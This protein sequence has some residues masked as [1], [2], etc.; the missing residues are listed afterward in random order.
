MRKKIEAMGQLYFL[1]ALKGIMHA[2]KVV[3]LI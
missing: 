3:V 1:K 2:G